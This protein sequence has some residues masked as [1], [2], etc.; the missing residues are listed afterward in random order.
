MLLRACYAMCGTEL[1]YAARHCLVRVARYWYRVCC[2]AICGTERAYA[3]TRLPLSRA[4]LGTVLPITL[5]A[6]PLS[7]YAHTPYH[8]T[9]AVRYA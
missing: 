2:Y 3:A 1:A 4:M 7:P 5:H 6:R 8:P 9:R